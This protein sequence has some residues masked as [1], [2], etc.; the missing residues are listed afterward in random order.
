MGKFYISAPV[1]EVKLA[2]RVAS[3]VERL[4]GR[5]P[6]SEE[7]RAASSESGMDFATMLLYRAIHGVPAYKGFIDAISAEPVATDHAPT[8]AKVLIIP[9]LF[10]GHYPETGADAALAAEIARTCGF[11]VDRIPVKSVGTVSG[12]AR[13]IR[14]WLLDERA[15]ALWVLTV[16]KGSADFR[17]FLQ[18]FPDCPAIARIRGWINVSGLANGCAISDY[19]IGSPW[20]ALK[21]RMICRL[22]GVSFELMHELTTRHPYWARS[23]EIPAHMRLFTFLAIPLPCHIQRAL[24][25]RYL[26]ISALGPNDGMVLCRDAILG[27]G[28]VFPV[29]GCDHFF[30]G[31]QVVTVLYKLFGY[32]RRL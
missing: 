2:Q 25:G 23:P 20:R 21:Y 32:L 30:R 19:N 12:N 29:W 28:P 11:E 13:I 4:N 14:D 17:A 10:H 5:L 16:S 7:L 26:A 3:A 18:M 22:F 24:M 6:T 1:D 27:A 9:A 31:P 8:A 15:E